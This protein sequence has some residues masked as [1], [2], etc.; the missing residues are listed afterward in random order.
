M[1]RKDSHDGQGQS[2]MAEQGRRR[3]DRGQAVVRQAGMVELGGETGG[4]P[5]LP[6]F[7]FPSELLFYSEDRRTHRS[8]LT[9][10]NPNSFSLSFR[11]Q[12]MSVCLSVR[13]SVCS[14]VCLSADLSVSLQS[15][16]QHPLSTEWWRL[17]ASSELNPASTCKY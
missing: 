3:G 14:P 4:V 16:V 17:R 1:R 5:R 9:V 7:L 12:Y 11:S 6:V 15:C 10:Y 13:L 8:V 2:G